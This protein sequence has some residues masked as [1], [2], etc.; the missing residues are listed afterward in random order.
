M[1][2]N[3]RKHSSKK[4]RYNAISKKNRAQRASDVAKEKRESDFSRA[5]LRNSEPIAPK[6]NHPEENTP[7]KKPNLN[8]KDVTIHLTPQIIEFT[9]PLI[10]KNQESIRNEKSQ[11]KKVSNHESDLNGA[12][13]EEKTL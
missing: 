7:T 13:E 1:S 5:K 10:E 12:S 11:N 2:H 8:L 4:G 3:C 9:P 6:V